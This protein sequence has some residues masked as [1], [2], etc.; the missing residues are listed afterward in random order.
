M[1]KSLIFTT[2]HTE[3]HD[4]FTIFCRHA[5]D[6]RE[7]GAC[8]VEYSS[9]DRLNDK[10][11]TTVLQ[12]NTR[13]RRK[14][15]GTKIMEYRVYKTASVTILINNTNI[16]R[17]LCFGRVLSGSVSS[18]LFGLIC[19]RIK[20]ACSELSIAVTGTSENSGSARYRFRSRYADD[21]LQSH[22]EYGL[23]K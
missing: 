22:D 8:L 14:N 21:L 6:N 17:A 10:S 4:G 1:A 20:S 5:R 3:R 7:A 9:G 23:K 13:F 11:L 19:S 2:H 18:A 15:T 16:N 12:N